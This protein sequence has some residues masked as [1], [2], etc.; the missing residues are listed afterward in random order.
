MNT[1]LYGWPY[2][3]L[4]GALVIV[5]YLLL[6]R[7]PAGSPKRW[8]DPAFVLPLLWPMYLVHQFEEHG[9][10]LHGRRYAF[11]GDL[12]A[13]LG[14]HDVAQCPADGAFIFAVNAMGAQLVFASALVFRR[15]N[16]VIAACAWGITLNAITHIGGALA[17]GAYNP[18]LATSVLLFVPL[19]VWMLRTVV[20]AG[21]LAPPQIARVVAVG[22]LVHVV[23]LASL[24]L[25][26]RGVISHTAM[27]AANVLNGLWPLALG[28]AGLKR[29]TASGA[30]LGGA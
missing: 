22:V 7:R 16:P 23:L 18:G 26:E 14:H 19:T 24:F 28:T 4:L 15:R 10:D 29:P 20:R 21:V 27:L 5:A 3:G 25:R 2:V 17:R 1:I 13:T 30:A 6:E 8:D 12:C 9:V 11:L